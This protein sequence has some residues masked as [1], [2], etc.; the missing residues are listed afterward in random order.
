VRGFSWIFTLTSLFLCHFF[1][2]FT[3]V[4]GALIAAIKMWLVVVGMLHVARVF[5][6]SRQQK[7]QFN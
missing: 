2:G 6:G 4:F 1:K 3:F 7:P 5:W